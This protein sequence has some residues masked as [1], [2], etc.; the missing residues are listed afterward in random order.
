MNKPSVVFYSGRLL[1]PSET[2]VRAQAEELSQFT[3]YYMGSRRVEGL[4]IPSERTVVV[5]PGTSLGAGKEAIYK[6]FG[7]AP[8][9]VRQIQAIAPQ[10][11]HAHFGVCAALAL[12]IVRR[13]KL[14]LVVT[15]YGLD[16]TM[17]DA[18]ART[19]SIS[20][21]VYLQ[22][23]DA[24]KRET[25]L[26]IAVSEFIR[27]RLIAQGF[28]ADKIIA[29]YYG[30]D[31]NRFQPDPRVERE[32]VVLFVGRLAEKKG[33]EYLIRA[34]AKVQVQN[35]EAELVVIGDGPLRGKLE[36]L[37]KRELYRY[38]FLGLQPSETVQQWMN[39]ARL[40]A[41][42]SVTA[43]SGDSEGL[44]TV[45]VEAQSMGLPVVGS[46]H[47]GI[48]QAIVPEETGFLVAE[49]DWQA[50]AAYILRLFEDSDLWQHC[51]VKAQERMRAEFDLS[52]QTQ[53]L[54]QIYSDVV[55]QVNDKKFLNN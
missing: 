7:Y 33:C 18:Y 48:P 19:H 46:I 25:D 34:M 29:H 11:I 44:P 45:V 9:L 28:P 15:F 51:S 35:E 23:R 22:R 36:A 6:W 55:Q 30:V 1:P 16:A 26:F 13:V 40:L 42:P 27:D 50:L 20:T 8:E 41:A 49:R 17:T 3:P 31:T 4:S 14:P 53:K 2:F 54:E 38:R 39:R 21:R 5:N 32:P 12:P 52:K 43:S 10:L 47:A 24:L 37:A